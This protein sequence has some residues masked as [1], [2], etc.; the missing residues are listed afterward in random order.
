MWDF[1]WYF[2]KRDGFVYDE[3]RHRA[4]LVIP[5]IRSD[6]IGKVIDLKKAEAASLADTL[7]LDQRWNVPGR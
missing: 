7:E 1:W 3:T 2:Y 6:F 4:R 5:H